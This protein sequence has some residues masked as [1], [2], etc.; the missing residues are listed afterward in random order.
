MLYPWEGGLDI[1]LFKAWKRRGSSCCV[2]PGPRGLTRGL[3]KPEG[4]VNFDKHGRTRAN[5]E[6]FDL[7][8]PV[9]GLFRTYF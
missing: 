3:K 5:L 9:G 6:V 7:F 1:R 2:L 4:P 8:R